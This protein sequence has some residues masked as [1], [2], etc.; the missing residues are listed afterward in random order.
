ML[1]RNGPVDYKICGVMQQCVYG[2]KIYDIYDLH[3]CLTQTWVD[4]T[5]RYQGCHW[6]VARQSEIMYA[7]WWQTLWT[8]AA[9][10]LFIC[11]MWF[12][13]TFYETVNV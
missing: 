1:H 2:T 9:K 3:K 10:L 4:W 5:E 11:I 13:R 6:P 8:H 12:I 7:C